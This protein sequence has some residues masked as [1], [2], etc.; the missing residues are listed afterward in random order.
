MQLVIE[1]Q[2][3]ADRLRLVIERGLQALGSPDVAT[4]AC[5]R[6][7]ELAKRIAA[8]EGQKEQDSTAA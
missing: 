8:R 3:D 5:R 2:E 7:K 4:E 1:S 6:Q